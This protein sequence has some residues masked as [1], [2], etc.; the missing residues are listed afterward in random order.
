MLEALHI[1]ERTGASRRSLIEKTPM[2]HVAPII[3]RIHASPAEITPD[4]TRVTFHREVL[5]QKHPEDALN[6]KGPSFVEK[7]KRDTGHYWNKTTEAWEHANVKQK[8]SIF[9]GV[10]SLVLGVLMAIPG[11]HHIMAALAYVSYLKLGL[12]AG[13][14][15]L[16]TASTQWVLLGAAG[17]A[18]VGMPKCLRQETHRFCGRLVKDLVEEAKEGAVGLWREFKRDMVRGTRFDLWSPFKKKNK[19]KTKTA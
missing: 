7:L 10:S 9:V 2:T 11:P 15:F 3:E 17:V 18:S 12:S 6:K 14:A 19:T 8:I 1:P 16:A 5:P 13:T 4:V